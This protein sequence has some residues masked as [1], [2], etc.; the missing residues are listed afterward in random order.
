MG[1][2]CPN[3]ILARPSLEAA[4]ILYILSDYPQ[5]VN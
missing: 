2:S 1:A 4:Y 5:K 3:W